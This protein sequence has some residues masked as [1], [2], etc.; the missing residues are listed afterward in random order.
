MHALVSDMG[1][2]F[3][4]LSRE[5]GISSQNSTFMV[6]EIEV[7]YIFDTPHLMKRIRDNLY[8]HNCYFGDDKIASWSHIVDFYNR[9]VKQWMRLAPKLSTIHIAPTNFQKMKVK[10]AVQIFSNCVAAGMCT[11]M[12]FG[13]LPSEAIGTIE[14][15]DHFDKLFD[16]LNSSSANNPKEYG[17]AFNGSA[18]QIEFLHEML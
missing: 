12:S 3:I 4:Q 17:K 6:D 16:I 13:F 1:S 11:Q 18:K 15:I 8:K 9:D 14:Y 10:Y 2:N 7:L 5:L